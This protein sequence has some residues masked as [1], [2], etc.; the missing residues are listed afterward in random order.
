MEQNGIDM[1]KTGIGYKKMIKINKTNV[2]KLVKEAWK[3]S[4]ARVE[5]IGKL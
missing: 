2:V 5:I 3:V 1:R 4:F